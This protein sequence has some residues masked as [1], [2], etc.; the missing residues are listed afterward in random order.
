M[1][2]CQGVGPAG[3]ARGSPL[4]LLQLPGISADARRSRGSGIGA[5]VASCTPDG[6]GGVHGS[7]ATSEAICSEPHALS[8][9]VP[10]KSM[11]ILLVPCTNCYKIFVSGSGR[12]PIVDMLMCSLIPVSFSNESSHS[13]R[14]RKPDVGVVHV[15]PE[16]L[17]AQSVHLLHTT[18]VT[19]LNRFRHFIPI[20]SI[21]IDKIPCSH[22][23]EINR[24]V[25]VGQPAEETPIPPNINTGCFS[26]KI[27]R[28]TELLDRIAST[29]KGIVY[30]L[31]VLAPDFVN[32]YCVRSI[33]L[34]RRIR[35]ILGFIAAWQQE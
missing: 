20:Q 10:V 15:V 12:E 24:G 34:E 19:N 9:I 29:T 25:S 8:R 27:T 11:P 30:D 23:L 2:I 7:S 26:K 33:G 32:V 4:H 35:A 5:L 31:F 22:L 18:S 6:G 14:S 16:G 1:E 21:V 13:R 28:L 17:A 3:S